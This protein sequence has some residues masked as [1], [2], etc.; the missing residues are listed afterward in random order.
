[1][2][3]ARG[4]DGRRVPWNRPRAILVLSH[5][6][7]RDVS[8]QIVARADHA[9]E[10]RFAKAEIGHERSRVRRIELRDL[11]LDLRADRDRSRRSARDERF[12]AR[13]RHGVIRPR[14]IR[15]VKIQHDEQRLGG[16]E[17]KPAEPFGVVR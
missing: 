3:L 7:E 2:N 9:I 11:E 1:M 8:E 6:E 13:E 10:P 15:F 4:N 5:S 14:E 17:L 16:E 12:D